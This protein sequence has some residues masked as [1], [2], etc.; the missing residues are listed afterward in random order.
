VV[1]PDESK[2]IWI[3]TPEELAQLAETD[4]GKRSG[5]DG[6]PNRRS[7]GRRLRVS[8]TAF[9]TDEP[10]TEVPKRD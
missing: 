9:G 5:R 7:T 8:G 2:E 3:P 1:K 10:S 6:T 4:R